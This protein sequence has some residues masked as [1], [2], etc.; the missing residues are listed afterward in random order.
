MDTL[1]QLTQVPVAKTGMLIRKPAAEVFAAFVEPQ[2]TTKFWFTKSSGRLE[3][4]RQIKWEWEMFGAST[5]LTVKALEPHKRI[6]IEWQ[7]YSGPTIVEWRFTPMDAGTFVTIIESG[8]TGNGDELVRYATTSTQGFT[9]TLAGL[10]ALL[11]HGIEL[12]LVRDRFP[13]GPQHP[14]PDQ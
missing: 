12:N 2:I 4:G 1:Q 10:K 5:Q 11:E 14:Y 8:F 9:W 3:P 7:G 13:N 6:V